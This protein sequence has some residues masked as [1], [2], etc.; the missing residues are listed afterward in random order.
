MTE[1]IDIPVSLPL[2][3]RQCFGLGAPPAQAFPFQGGRT[4]YYYLARNAIWH[5]AGS[6]GLK[7]GDEILMPGYH[8]GVELE[9]LIAKGMRVRCYRVD[10]EMRIDMDDLRAKLRKETRALYITHYLGYPQP[11]TELKR[12]ADEAGIPLIEDCA[13][14]LYSASPEGPLGITGDFSVFCLYKSI[15]V[16][17]G[18]AL[19]LNRA[20]LPLPPPPQEPDSLS[21]MAYVLYGLLDSLLLSRVPGGRSLA[22]GLRSL[23]RAAK[24]AT[25]S[26]VVQID[27]EEFD[28]SAMN[29][30]TREI[31]RRIVRYTDPA[32]TVAI[33]RENYGRMA[34]RLDPA[35]RRVLPPLPAGACPLSFPIFVKEKVATEQALRREGIG[36][37]NMWSRHHP[38]SP[39]GSFPDVDYLRR[40]VLELPIHQ[41]MRAEHVDFVAE[42]AS[43]LARWQGPRSGAGG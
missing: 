7:A 17:Q 41:G 12:I 19:V 10:R 4:R 30:G 6:L 26:T 23:A 33:R 20:D 35:V 3:P 25:G 24:H 29:M 1:T 16:P 13:L 28:V 14:S 38:A 22:H 40:H 8:H 9:T 43:A 27:T 15:P 36:T 31:A 34:D 11:A 39:E 21:T 42:K 18:G 37:I 2:S 5:G 32:R